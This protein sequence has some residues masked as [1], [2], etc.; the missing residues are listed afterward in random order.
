VRTGGH[1]IDNRCHAET[2]ARALC[3]SLVGQ[4]VLT[5]TGWLNA[6]LGVADD[7]V[8]VATTRSP[9][10]EPVPIRMGAE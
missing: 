4:Q 6:L 8:V 2:D 9:D 7:S 5:V 1:A 3:E 10:G